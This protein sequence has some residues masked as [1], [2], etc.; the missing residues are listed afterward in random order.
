M[1]QLQMR[2]PID[3]SVA[4]ATKAGLLTPIV[5]NVANKNIIQISELVKALAAKAK[6]GKLQPNEFMG[7]TFT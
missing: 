3:I 7:G 5:P 1:L 4:V 6:D 2:G